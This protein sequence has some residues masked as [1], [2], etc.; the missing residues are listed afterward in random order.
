MKTEAVMERM[1]AFSEG[2]LHDINHFV[3]VYGYAQ[4]IGRLE[5]LDDRTQLALEIAAIVH[6]I[7]C[8]LCREKYVMQQ[9][10]CRSRKALRWLKSCS[11]TW[12]NRFLN[13]C[14]GWSGI[15]TPIRM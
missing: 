15:I 10:S 4:T 11:R 9:A 3:K 5:G 7:A 8:P 6:D 13:G 12:K 1:I 2:N 14:A